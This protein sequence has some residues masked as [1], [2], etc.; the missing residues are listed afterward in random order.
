MLNSNVTGLPTIVSMSTNSASYVGANDVSGTVNVG[1]GPNFIYIS[2]LALQNPGL[3]YVIVGDNSVW[4]RAPVVSEIKLGS[5][6]NGLSPAYFR[7]LYYVSSNA[8]SA[9]LA[10]KGMNSSSKYTLYLV[11][12]DYNPFDNANFGVI[13]S[14]PIVPEVASWERMVAIGMSILLLMMF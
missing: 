7:V 2:N 3:V 10:W 1:I 8:S 11:A 6:P 4:P 5:G 14:Y 12:S 9:N 13:H